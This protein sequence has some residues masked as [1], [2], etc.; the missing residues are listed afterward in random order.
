M[1][2]TLGE[3]EVCLIVKQFLYKKW[4]IVAIII[5]LINIENIATYLV[6]K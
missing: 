6:N 3:D 4:Q 5:V 2:N 1:S